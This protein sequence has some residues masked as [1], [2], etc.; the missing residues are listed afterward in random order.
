MDAESPP[1][2]CLIVKDIDKKE[3]DYERTVRKYTKII[4]DN[5]LGDV[6]KKVGDFVNSLNPDIWRIIEHLKL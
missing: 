6:V 3:R 5:D 4:Q 2:V 1:E